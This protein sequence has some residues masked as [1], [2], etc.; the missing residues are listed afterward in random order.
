MR[1]RSPSTR[2]IVA[3]PARMDEL[4]V[5][6]LLEE[7]GKR[8]ECPFLARSSQLSWVESLGGLASS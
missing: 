6:V 8:R 3:D 2:R 1:V 4:P 7:E 5:E